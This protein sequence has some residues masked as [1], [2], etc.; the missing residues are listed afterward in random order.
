MGAALEKTEGKKKKRIA[1]FP[2][3]HC[4]GL[5]LFPGPETSTCHGHGQRKEMQGVSDVA[6][7]VKNLTSNHEDV[8]L[9]RGI[10][11]RVAVSCGASHRCSSYS[12]PGLG[13]YAADTAQ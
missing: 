7:Q 9:I 4:S 5:G 6:Q 13:T 10:T 11:Q 2:V 1:S 8:G 12:T 3:V